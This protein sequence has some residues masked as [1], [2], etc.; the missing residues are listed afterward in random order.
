M[1]EVEGKWRILVLGVILML[2]DLGKIRINAYLQY[3]FRD[4]VRRALQGG[5][6]YHQLEQAPR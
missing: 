2:V 5:S 1:R 3:V 6:I 4:E